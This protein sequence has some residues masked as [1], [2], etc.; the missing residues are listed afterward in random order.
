M[1]CYDRIRY[2]ICYTG[3]T[4][5]FLFLHFKTRP[6]KLGCLYTRQPTISLAANDSMQIIFIHD[7][8][9]SFDFEIKKKPPV[10]NKCAKYEYERLELCTILLDHSNIGIYP[11]ATTATVYNFK[12]KTEKQ[13]NE[14]VKQKLPQ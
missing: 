7:F 14:F 5:L 3:S 2:G 6:R 13:L 11:N 1:H 12:I 10:C 8:I 9:G 4:R